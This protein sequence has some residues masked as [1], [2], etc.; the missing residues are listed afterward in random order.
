M[1]RCCFRPEVENEVSILARRTTSPSNQPR[2]RVVPALAG[3]KPDSS[4]RGRQQSSLLLCTSNASASVGSQVQGVQASGSSNSVRLTGPWGNGS[5][6]A[7]YKD[8]D[9]DR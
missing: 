2:S 8:P 5:G 7:A 3:A 1:F 6:K 4:L 9:Q